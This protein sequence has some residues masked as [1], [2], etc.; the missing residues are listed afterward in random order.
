[1][2]KIILLGMLILI[3]SGCLEGKLSPGEAQLCLLSTDTQPSLIPECKTPQECE[4][5]LDETHPM[6]VFEQIPVGS[7]SIRARKGVAGAWSAIRAAS[8]SIEQIHRGCAA[9][10]IADILPGAV[11]SA[12]EL[13]SALRNSEEAQEFTYRTLQRAVVRG[14]ELELEN[15][16]DTKAFEEYAEIVQ[17]V[18]GMETQNPVSEWSQMQQ[19]NREYFENIGKQISQNKAG[20][21]GVEWNAVYGTYR[22]GVNIA[23]PDR[24][25]ILMAVSPLW[26]G[27]LSAFLGKRKSGNALSLV[28]TIRANEVIAQLEQVTAPQN[29]IIFEA[30]EK[31]GKFD[32]AISELAAEEEQNNAK[33]AEAIV[34]ME[35]KARIIDS[36]GKKWK[37]SGVLNGENELVEFE[38]VKEDDFIEIVR[39]W[40]NEYSA[41]HSARVQNSVPIGKRAAEWR[42]WQRKGESIREKMEKTEMLFEKMG[43]ECGKWK[44]GSEENTKV[45]ADDCAKIVDERILLEN[46]ANQKIRSVNEGRL[47]ACVKKLNNV[48]EAL[49]TEL[50]SEEWFVEYFENAKSDACEAALMS[51]VREYDNQF[52][53]K[54]WKELKAVMQQYERAL[55]NASYTLDWPEE[56]NALEKM[57][58]IKEMM[59]GEKEFLRTEELQKEIGELENSQAEIENA[60]REM[61]NGAFAEAKWKIVYPEKISMGKEEWVE[62]EVRVRAHWNEQLRIGSLVILP[63]P[64]IESIEEISDGWSGVV[65][66]EMLIFESE[67]IGKEDIIIRGKGSGAWVRETGRV[68]RVNTLGDNAQVDERFVLE[69]H[70]YPIQV[71]GKWFPPETG[72]EA[73]PLVYVGGK[74]ASI[75]NGEWNAR[76]EK[77]ATEVRISYRVNDLIHVDTALEN[78]HAEWGREFT[79]YRVNVRNGL[80]GEVTANI[81]TGVS[82]AGANSIFISNENGEKVS[83]IVDAAGGIV[84]VKQVIPAQGT[85]SY[86]VR[87]ER[88]E[89]LEEWLSTVEYLRL[90]LEAL[91]KSSFQEISSAAKKSKMKMYALN[92]EKNSAALAQKVSE[93]QM[94]VSGLLV[95]K[96]LLEEEFAQLESEWMHALQGADENNLW[97]R[98]GEAARQ[99][100][101]FPKWREALVKLVDEKENKKSVDEKKSGGENNW[102]EENVQI[103]KNASEAASEYEKAI[104]VGC[105][106][107]SGVGFICPIMEDSLKNSKKILSNHGK[108]IASME[109]K[110]VKLSEEKQIEEWRKN[111]ETWK[112]MSEELKQIQ[113][114]ME[115]ALRSVR[116]TSVERVAEL[117]R[118]TSGNSNEDIVSAVAKANA[119]NEKGEFGKGLFVAQSVLLFVNGS[120]ATGLISLPPVV[121]PIA[122]VILLVIVWIGWKEWKKKNQV[123]IQK[124]VI[125][126]AAAM[127]EMDLKNAASAHPATRG[128]HQ[129]EHSK[130]TGQYTRVRTRVLARRKEG[131]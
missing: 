122:G 67:N 103:W 27:A 6:R 106:K 1:M 86:G 49:D 57:K 15:V 39:E 34:E 45:S 111:Q 44:M 31:M 121:W 116:N 94:E 77:G 114:E 88:E 60:V 105:E 98:A 89:G 102:L 35:E 14:A 30:W 100:M 47:R 8:T 90:E 104:S 63:N 12:S 78:H 126:R 11:A 61:I 3:G 125:P 123:V 91:E 119:A 120:K 53:V 73:L 26:Q 19:S 70:F 66:G 64:G 40:K 24:V 128:E 52:L 81:S 75:Q 18:H 95:K 69:T 124:Q 5:R 112:E 109:K 9:L 93:M 33:G 48:E 7:D 117:K 36:E 71:S 56:K 113:G 37:N 21:Y 83:E 38:Y 115:S 23:V 127:Q 20:K 29:G 59:V 10:S 42:K 96:E 54:E 131:S 85:R 55:E 58:Q 68:W 108:T 2:R 41:L 84:L 51:R 28:S 107:L 50:T 99:K 97:V 13:Q 72:M 76:L 129:S 4:A 17:M 65:D 118:E 92:N 32:S 130:T 74:T 101:N 16:K 25:R 110:M 62:I 79:Y 82:G 80:S 43:A 22:T 46:N 87:V